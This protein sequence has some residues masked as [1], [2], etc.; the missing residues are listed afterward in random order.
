MKRFL[1][2]S[3]VLVFAFSLAACAGGNDTPAPTEA[4]QQAEA[5]AEPTAE[6]TEPADQPEGAWRVD[7]DNDG[8]DEQLVLNIGEL[9][10][11]GSAVPYVLFADGTRLELPQVA[12]SHAGAA[13]Y[14]ITELDGRGYVL[15]Y[16]PSW[17]N[18]TVEDYY[19]LYSAE[20]GQLK[21]ARSGHVEFEVSS[22]R[23]LD[24]VDI[25]GVM[26][27]VDEINDIWQHSRLAF[28]TD[29]YTVGRNLYSRPDGALHLLDGMAYF[30]APEGRDAESWYYVEELK[31]LDSEFGL[32]DP[33]I[34]TVYTARQRL[35]IA[36]AKMAENRNNADPSEKLIGL[37]WPAAEKAMA[38][39][40]GEV[41]REYCNFESDGVNAIVTFYA[42]DVDP[43]DYDFSDPS[44]SVSFRNYDDADDWGITCVNYY[45]S[46]PEDY[47]WDAYAK[48]N[49]AIPAEMD[50]NITAV[51]VSDAAWEAAKSAA[52]WFTE[53]PEN[54]VFRCTDAAP[55][56]IATGENYTS[57]Q[58]Q[59]TVTIGFVPKDYRAFAHRWG[60]WSHGLCIFED[61]HNLYY[62][63]DLNVWLIGTNADG[64]YHI[65][66]ELPEDGPWG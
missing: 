25:D 45:M 46:F 61:E 36:N 18:G 20:N 59:Y 38:M 62:T 40:G 34:D 55:L 11:N 47:D 37:A 65:G 57:E 1:I 43:L 9:E 26:A 12:A 13:T 44:I 8:A 49:E 23:P 53:L 48:Q 5:T 56:T 19:C 7:L 30:A 14:G 2:L 64:S 16:R 22:V 66:I 41:S 63:V 27:F 28:T 60:E 10:E 39:Y 17:Y 15:Y 29:I 33:S 24:P 50:F 58:P 52:K 42:T 3:L 32:D 4:D 54:S 6:A 21:E 31:R 51:S 35:E